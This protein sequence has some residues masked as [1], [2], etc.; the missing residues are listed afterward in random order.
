MPG[1]NRTQ[2]KKSERGLCISPYCRNKA[3][4]ASKYC[5]KCRKRRY[6]ETFPLNYTYSYIKN[7]AKRRGH[8]FT[9][10]LQE[11][12]EFCRATEYMDF[13]GRK[14]YHFTIDRIDNKKGY[15]RDNIRILTQSEN[16]IKGNK[17]RRGY[18]V[19]EDC[20]F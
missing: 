4:K 3:E 8:E 1:I 7:N 12:T 15:T 16:A 2:K 13:K 19:E 6:R 20:P 5:S 17:E 14:R 9:L 10:S 18:Y 11:F